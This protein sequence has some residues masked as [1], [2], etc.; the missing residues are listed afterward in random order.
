LFRAF[1]MCFYDIGLWHN[2]SKTAINKLRSC[3]NKC[4]KIFF[5]YERI[6]SV[7][8]MLVELKLPCFDTLYDMCVSKFRSRWLSCINDL[9]SHLSTLCS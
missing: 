5:G 9:I 4:I 3:Y 2:F 1:C 7:T 6:D 8:A